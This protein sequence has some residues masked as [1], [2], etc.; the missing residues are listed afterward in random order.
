MVGADIDRVPFRHFAIG[1]GHHVGG[2][3]Q[4][5]FGREDVGAA[6]EIFLD[7]IVLGGAG[8]IGPL[9]PLGLGRRDIERQQPGRRRVDRHGRVHLPK[10]NAVEQGL[11]VAQM[12]DRHADL[13][14]LALGQRMVGIVAGLGRQVERHRETRLAPRKIRS[15]ELVALRSRGMARISAKKPGFVPFF[16]FIRWSCTHGGIPLARIITQFQR[17]TR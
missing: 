7:D 6:R 17:L 5:G 2:Q 1:E 12:A 15:I 4:G 9:R 3:T 11:H 16:R 10:R 13:A 8:Q 14:D